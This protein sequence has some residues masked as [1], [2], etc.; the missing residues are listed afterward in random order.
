MNTEKLGILRTG[1][2]QWLGGAASRP[3]TMSWRARRPPPSPFLKTWILTRAEYSDYFGVDYD[4]WVSE[5]FQRIGNKEYFDAGTLIG[6]HIDQQGNKSNTTRG[7]IHYDSSGGAHIV[8]A[9]PSAPKP[10]P[11]T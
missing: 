4:Q 10:K 6:T 7:A 1:Q 3:P 11:K 9:P 2:N 8:P 5:N